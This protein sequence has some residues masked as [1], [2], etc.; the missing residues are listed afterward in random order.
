MFVGN[1]TTGV[2]AVIR[3]L[4][5]NR[6]DELLTTD[7]NYNACHNVLVEMARRSSAAGDRDADPDDGRPTTRRHSPRRPLLIGVVDILGLLDDRYGVAELEDGTVLPEEVLAR[8]ACDSAMGRVVMAGGSIPFDLGKVTYSP[9]AGQRRALT[10]RDKGCIVPG[11]DRKARWCEPHHVVP[12][13][14]GPTDLRNLV[15]LCKRHH[16]Q[17]HRE[18]IE[19]VPGET[20]GRWIV[21]RCSDD[22]PLR[23]RPPPQLAA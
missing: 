20:E 18:I 19:L 8:W 14:E 15:L 3:S 4:R 13:P 22:T 21:V 5:L 11:C 12:W 7:Q 16:R 1:A 10:A 6:G 17:V 9:S 23:E 2:N